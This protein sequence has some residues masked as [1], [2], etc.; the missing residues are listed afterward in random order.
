MRW[1]A[2]ALQWH[3]RRTVIAI[4]LEHDDDPSLYNGPPYAVPETVFDETDL[5]GCDPVVRPPAPAAGQHCKSWAAARR[6]SHTILGLSEMEDLEHLERLR[7][8]FK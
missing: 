8:G 5:V 2:M 1:Q 4:P 6:R 7:K 3:G